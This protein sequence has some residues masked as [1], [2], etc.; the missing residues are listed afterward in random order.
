MQSKRGNIEIMNND[1]T[2]ENRE[3]IFKILQKRYQN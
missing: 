3:E 2:D 1:K